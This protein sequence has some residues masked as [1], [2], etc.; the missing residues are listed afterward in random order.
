MV[1]TKPTRLPAW[2]ASLL[3]AVTSAAEVSIS[4]EKSNW[5]LAIGN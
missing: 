5:Q 1:G 2:R 4:M 3:M